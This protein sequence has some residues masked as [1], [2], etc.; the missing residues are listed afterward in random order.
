M[1][2]LGLEVV[3][4][5]GIACLLAVQCLLGLFAVFFVALFALVFGHVG[6]PV[7]AATVSV[8]DFQLVPCRFRVLTPIA[9][10][11]AIAELLLA[12]LA[13]ANGFA[14]YI[15]LEL[16]NLTRRAEPPYLNVMHEYI[17]I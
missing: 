10:G 2:F 4:I 15:L 1:L 9:I 12:L 5:Q 13:I 6:Q 7:V 14:H 3:P 8:E 11:P 17:P 16:V